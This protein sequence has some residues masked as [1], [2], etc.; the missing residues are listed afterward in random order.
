MSN[1]RT[2][3]TAFCMNNGEQII[4]VLTTTPIYHAF[5]IWIK[6]RSEMVFLCMF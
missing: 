6:T 3:L 4:P 1:Q 5:V 2:L